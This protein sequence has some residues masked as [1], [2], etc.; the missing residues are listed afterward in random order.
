MNQVQDG[1]TGQEVSQLEHP[2]YIDENSS[3]GRVLLGG[4]CI[5]DCQSRIDDVVKDSVDQVER[6][7]EDGEE[8]GAAEETVIFG[9][10]LLRLIVF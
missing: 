8:F 9:A 3:V 10:L 1:H 4:L 7:D 2:V 6:A 5:Q